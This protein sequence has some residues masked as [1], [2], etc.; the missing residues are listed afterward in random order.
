MMSTTGATWGICLAT[1]A[2]VIARPFRWPEA[3]W[4]VLGAAL[5]LVFGLLALSSGLAAIGKGADVY[6][7][8]IGM[9]VPAGLRHRHR[10]H[11]VSVQ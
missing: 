4:A 3:I 5:L 7:F 9:A 2:A 8:L 11:D 6:L 10:H 1:T